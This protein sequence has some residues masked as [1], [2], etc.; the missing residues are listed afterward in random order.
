MRPNE[1]FCRAGCEA[2]E[3]QEE[4]EDDDDDDGTFGGHIN[5]RNIPIFLSSREIL[6]VYNNL[7]WNHM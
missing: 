1:V 7:C 5:L 2:S 6:P 4:E 3:T